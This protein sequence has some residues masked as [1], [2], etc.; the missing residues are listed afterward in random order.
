MMQSMIILKNMEWLYF[1]NYALMP[2]SLF[3][4]GVAH[5]HVH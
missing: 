3:L 5:A 1:I 2:K 4:S